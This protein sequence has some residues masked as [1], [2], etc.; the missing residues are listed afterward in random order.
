MH[1][2]IVYG[3]R[4]LTIQNITTR[5]TRGNCVGSSHNLLWVGT[6]PNGRTNKKAEQSN[7]HVT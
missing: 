7:L 6:Q 5:E 4:S 3:T 1:I 2:L